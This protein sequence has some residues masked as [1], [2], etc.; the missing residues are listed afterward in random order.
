M[1]ACRYVSHLQ[2]VPFH[3]EIW[4]ATASAYASAVYAVTPHESV[5]FPYLSGCSFS[6]FCDEVFGL[7]L[8]EVLCKFVMEGKL[9]HVLRASVL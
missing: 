2:L 3:L 1:Y 9:L 6:A 8:Q 4:V 5:H 7:F